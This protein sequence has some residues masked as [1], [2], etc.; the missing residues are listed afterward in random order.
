[1]AHCKEGNAFIYSA[2]ITEIILCNRHCL[3]TE[4]TL[5]DTGRDGSYLC[6]VY[7]LMR[8]DTKERREGRRQGGREEGREKV[9]GKK[10]ESDTCPE[11][12]KRVHKILQIAMT[13]SS[14]ESGIKWQLSRKNSRESLSEKGLFELLSES[15]KSLG[16]DTPVTGTHCTKT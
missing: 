8:T 12:N 4:E 13:E 5:V 10:E 1:M 6:G 7:S 3:D 11:E 16:K 9:G 14:T 15:C 2:N